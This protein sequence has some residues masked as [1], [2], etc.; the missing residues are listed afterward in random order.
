MTDYVLKSRISDLKAAIN[1]IN[2][3]KMDI[4]ETADKFCEKCV[5]RI[6]GSC[7]AL[8][9]EGALNIIIG[10]YRELHTQTKAAAKPEV[11]S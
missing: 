2:L 11:T 4:C 9:A 8:D 3:I 6:D 7:T 10:K 5:L 1:T